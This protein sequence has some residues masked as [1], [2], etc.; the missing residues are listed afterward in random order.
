MFFRLGRRIGALFLGSSRTCPTQIVLLL[1][2]RRIQTASVVPVF[3]GRAFDRA[4]IT[5]SAASG[6][7]GAVVVIRGVETGV[8][9]GGRG[10]VGV[11]GGAETDGGSGGD[12]TKRNDSERLKKNHVHF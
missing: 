5:T 11:T 2:R 7:V 4:F 9:A 10:A 12:C 1:G 6:Q 8:V 3:S